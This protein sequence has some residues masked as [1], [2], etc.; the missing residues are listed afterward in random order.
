MEE[1]VVTF[2]LFHCLRGE[3]GKAVGLYKVESMDT[4]SLGEKPSHQASPPAEMG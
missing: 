4:R 3:R 2:H 1:G